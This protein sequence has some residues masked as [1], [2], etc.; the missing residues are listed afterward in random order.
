MSEENPS[1]KNL[2][3]EKS[4]KKDK[5]ASAKEVAEAMVANMQANMRD[6]NFLEERERLLDQVTK[7]VL[8]KRGIRKEREKRKERAE[9][10]EKRDES[11]NSDKPKTT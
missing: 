4:T 9:K 8:V 6:P 10:E 3:E 7:E 5:N 11:N 2:E 1:Q